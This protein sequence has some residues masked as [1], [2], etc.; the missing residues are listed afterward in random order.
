M[1]QVV[2]G[3]CAVILLLW[4]VILILLTI[5]DLS[6]FFLAVASLGLGFVVSWAVALDYFILS[7]EAKS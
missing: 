1:N 2:Q 4:I 6:S 7:A 5:P 3:S